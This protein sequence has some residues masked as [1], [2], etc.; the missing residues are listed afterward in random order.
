MVGLW[1]L[2]YV[3][4]GRLNSL[5]ESLFLGGLLALEKGKTGLL[6][7]EQ[8]QRKQGQKWWGGVLFLFAVAT[9]DESEDRVEECV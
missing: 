7:E 2:Q 3:T 1:R 9:R 6:V 8:Q 5:S 4:G